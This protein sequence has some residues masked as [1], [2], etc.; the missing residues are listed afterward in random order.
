MS[1]YAQMLTTYRPRR[2]HGAMPSGDTCPRC[3][4]PLYWNQRRSA[5]H[6]RTP[7]P[8]DP[9]RLCRFTCLSAVRPWKETSR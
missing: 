6:C 8:N 3:G 9:L 5:A 7:D 2:S 4:G 1:H